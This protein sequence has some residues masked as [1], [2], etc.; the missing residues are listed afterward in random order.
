MQ[1][2]FASVPVL[3]PPDQMKDTSYTWNACGPELLIV[4]NTTDGDWSDEAK[5]RGWSYMH[6]MRNT[7]VC[8]SWNIA[9]AWFL[10]RSRSDDHLFLFSAS[11]RF[12][13][14][15]PAVLDQLAAAANWKGCQ[16]QYGPHAL[17]WSRKTL[18]IVGTWDENYVNY[19][20]DTDYFYRAILEGII[21]AGRGAMPQI[22]LNAPE[23]EDGRAIRATGLITHTASCSAYFESKWNGPP[24]GERWTTPF[25]SGLP[26]WWWSPAVRPGLQHF[27][28]W[29][30]RYR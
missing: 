12:D 25:D 15:L 13:D 30:M 4:D 8:A 2:I 9:R 21:V 6:F 14:G 7:G 19:V 24:S 27:D 10:N 20:G 3:Q 18:E 5:L 26:T 1:V 23:P 29:E 16:S 17:A 11:V 22:E 28:P